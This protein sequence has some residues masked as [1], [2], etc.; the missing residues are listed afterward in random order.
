[1]DRDDPRPRKV[2]S[3][4]EGGWGSLSGS[5]EVKDPDTPSCWGDPLSKRTWHADQGV[6]CPVLGPLYL[7]GQFGAASEEAGLSDMKL[8]GRTGLAC[9][10]PVVPGAEVLLRS[11]PGVSYCDP[12]RPERSQERTDWLVELQA[13][14]PLIFGI[15]LEYQCSALPSLTPL[16]QDQVSQDVRLAMPVGHSGKLKLGARQRWTVT[17]DQRALPESTQLYVGLELAR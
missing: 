2:S 5:V 4:T 1:L 16:V 11:G 10:V 8:T 6:R 15:G 12:L 3:R 14:C 17:S 13:R 9:K 7:F